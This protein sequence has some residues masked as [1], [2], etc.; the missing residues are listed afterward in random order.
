MQAKILY[1]SNVRSAPLRHMVHLNKMK[2][3]CVPIDVY[4]KLKQTKVLEKYQNNS[5]DIKP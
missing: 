4:I 3:F 2:T 1:D 5:K